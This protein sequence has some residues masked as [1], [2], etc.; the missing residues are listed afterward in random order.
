[1]RAKYF[2][3]GEAQPH[4]KLAGSLN[5][6][7][8][9]LLTDLTQ[10]VDFTLTSNFTGRKDAVRNCSQA[11]DVLL[12]NSLYCTLAKHLNSAVLQNLSRL[13]ILFLFNA[14]VHQRTYWCVIVG[15]L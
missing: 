7:L 14:S 9:A 13:T 5:K 10:N 6:S 3:P 11:S 8:G 12:E 2:A 15:L 1:M 4:S